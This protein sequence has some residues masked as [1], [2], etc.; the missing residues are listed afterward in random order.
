M[1]KWAVFKKMGMYTGI[2]VVPAYRP[3]LR[4]VGGG[5]GFGG[6]FNIY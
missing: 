1:I 5:G 4:A 2:K 6:N 3:G